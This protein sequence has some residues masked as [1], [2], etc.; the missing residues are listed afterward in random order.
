MS[1]LVRLYPQAWR[2]RYGDEFAAL[3][4]E[5]P[6]TAGDVLDTLRG[7]LDAHLH[8]TV[9]AS[10]PAPWTH[11]L[12][13]L[14]ALTAGLLLSGLYPLHRASSRPDRSTRA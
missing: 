6:P 2:D 7:A 13:G 3:L 10:E 14:L 11:R 8:P 1:R 12:P 5:R 4:E 9:G